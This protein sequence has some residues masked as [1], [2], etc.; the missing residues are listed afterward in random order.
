MVGEFWCLIFSISDP[1][2]GIFVPLTAQSVVASLLMAVG[3]PN[4][5]LTPRGYIFC[6]LSQLSLKKSFFQLRTGVRGSHG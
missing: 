3:F 4:S 1:Y 5:L 2:Y 6:K